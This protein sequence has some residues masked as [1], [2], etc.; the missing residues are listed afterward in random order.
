MSSLYSILIVDDEASLRSTLTRILQ[1]IGCSVTSA[2][3]GTEAIRL[4]LTNVFDLVF[5]DLRLPDMHGIEILREL[6]NNHPQL[7]VIVLTAYGS[8]HS[9][10]EA[11]HLEVTDYLIKPIDPEV[12]VN[13]T[14]SILKSQKI[15]KRR[16]EIQDHIS[17]LQAELASLDNDENEP[18]HSSAY[19][20]NTEGRY[21]KLGQFTLDL[22]TRRATQG[23]SPLSLPPATFD[24]FLVL[25]RHA[26][27][28]V[29]YQNLVIEAQGYQTN[30]NEARELA[31]WHIHIIRQSIEKDPKWPRL[32]LNVRGIGYQLVV[33]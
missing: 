6:R 1:G 21:L 10:V 26:P 16:K 13:R 12:L 28:V 8:I 20:P 15:A 18:S 19:L 31:K 24:Y 30:V 9:A 25:A 11:M 17:A 27:D 32:L 3:N 5:L 29:R 4:L 14:K 2:S 7:P 33:D 22:H 23:D